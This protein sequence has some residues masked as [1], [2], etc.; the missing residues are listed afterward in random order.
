MFGTAYAAS[1]VVRSTSDPSAGHRLLISIAVPFRALETRNCTLQPCSHQT[2]KEK[3]LSMDRDPRRLGP[4]TLI[5]GLFVPER[6]TGEIHQSARG[7]DLR[8][9]P[10]FLGNG[11][12]GIAASG[13]F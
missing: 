9:L 3:L 1:V 11:S 6:G 5:T 2:L 4:S 13:R 12:L 8:V 7:G 10:T